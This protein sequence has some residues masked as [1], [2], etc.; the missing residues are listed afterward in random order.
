M[1]SIQRYS[2]INY[3]PDCIP[4]AQLFIGSHEQTIAAAELFLQKIFCARNHCNT[5]IDCMQIR[6]RQHY[7]IQWLHPEK[8]YTIEQFEEMN[9][10]LSFQLEEN[11]LFFFVIQ[12]ADFLTTACA[13]KLLKPIE[14]PPRGYHFIILAERTHNIVPT[15]IS[16]CVLHVLK[17][18]NAPHLVTHP[19]YEVF[20]QKLPSIQEFSKYLDT[21]HIN[22]RET[23]ELIDQILL[24][25]HNEYKR[26]SDTTKNNH[27][28][29]VI[30][31]LQNIQHQLPMPASSI[32]FWRNLYL[33]LS[34]VQ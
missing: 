24:Y 14:E 12:K 22:E 29:Q 16:R 9:N 11:Q 27:R 30:R 32:L 4:P 6:Q 31:I 7:A 15:I 8:Y 34:N 21:I 33:L 19:L 13:N 17:M 10:V 28:E 3:T 26:E 18:S 25:W 2:F 5:C 1:D 20:T 23:I